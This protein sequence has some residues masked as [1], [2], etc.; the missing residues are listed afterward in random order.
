MEIRIFDSKDQDKIFYGEM[1]H[2]F[3][4]KKIRQEM[5][6]WQFYNKP[7]SVWFICYDGSEIVGFCAMYRESTHILFDNFYV[8]PCQRGK[9]ISNLL[10]D[11]RMEFCQKERMELR[12]ITDNPIQM[13]HYERHCFEFYGNRGRY[14]KYRKDLK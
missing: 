3:A 12:A 7:D 13:R 2:F 14:K 10:F 1:G 5:G 9:R 8:L 4:D 6:G 11:A